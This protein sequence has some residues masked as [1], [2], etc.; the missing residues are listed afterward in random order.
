MVPYKDM[1]LIVHTEDLGWS[2]C[3][4]IVYAYIWMW[5]YFMIYNNILGTQ[6]CADMR[7]YTQIHVDVICSAL[8]SSPIVLYL[9]TC[10]IITL[11]I[12]FLLCHPAHTLS[13]KAYALNQFYAIF[14]A[15]WQLAHTPWL[16]AIFRTCAQVTI[17]LRHSHIELSQLLLSNTNWRLYESGVNLN[18][19][20][21]EK[22]SLFKSLALTICIY[23]ETIYTNSQHFHRICCLSIFGKSKFWS[24]ISDW[25]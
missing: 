9:W 11:L 3:S 21:V 1:L 10:N 8:L 20:Q 16:Y 19:R 4:M 13:I 14:Y 17:I 24:I 25:Q 2:P 7:R 15:A 23:I 12:L 5:P 6:I 22:L 18:K